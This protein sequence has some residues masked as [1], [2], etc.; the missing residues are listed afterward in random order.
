MAPVLKVSLHNQLAPLPSTCGGTARGRCVGEQAIHSACAENVKRRGSLEGPSIL[1]D[2][3][4]KQGPQTRS[5]PR[6]LTT[7]Q[8]TKLGI[9]SL[10]HKPVEKFSRF[11]NSIA[12]TKK[13]K[14]FFKNKI[15]TVGKRNSSLSTFKK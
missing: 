3:R 10:T 14:I 1:C 15:I 12:K 8:G 4:S 5:Q 2:T 6:V 13:K 11:K 9:K 7:S